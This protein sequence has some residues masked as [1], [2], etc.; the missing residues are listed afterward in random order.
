[1]APDLVRNDSLSRSILNSLPEHI[2]VLDRSGVI[3][4]VNDSWKRFAAEHGA[5]HNPRTEVG[6]NYL[7]ISEASSTSAPEASAAVE[8]IRQVLAGSL[9]RYVTEYPCHAPHERHWFR[10]EVLPFVGDAPGV[11][12]AHEDITQSRLAEERQRETEELLRTLINATPDLICFKDEAGRWLQA[13]ASILNLYHLT[14]TDYRHKAEPELAE[15]TAPIYQQAFRNCE[16]SDDKAWQNGGLTRSEEVIADAEGNEREYDVIKVPLYHDDN[17]RKGLVVFGRDITD[18]KRA[19]ANVI[20]SLKEKETLLREV[21]HR[22]K[23]NMQVITSLLSLHTEKTADPEA[24]RLLEDT[25][26]RVRSMALV[27]DRLYKSDMLSAIPFKDYLSEL[28]DQLVSDHGKGRAEIHLDVDDVSLGIGSAIPAGLIINELVTNSLSH[29]FPKESK[30]RVDVVLKKVGDRCSLMISD[31][32]TGFPKQIDYRSTPT[33]GMQLV[34]TLVDQLQ[35]KIALQ[36]DHG[37]KWSIDF[38]VKDL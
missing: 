23:N 20:S 36:T 10:M 8:G 28:T 31:N 3:V 18:A 22:V 33:L 12:V 24:R 1:V 11:I 37:T 5:P 2:A 9:P 19:E 16:N 35:G 13:N 32:G 25:S 6:A 38:R 4:A 30:G 27:H 26:A 21:H 34:T 7:S 14:G 29:A 15:F 17:T